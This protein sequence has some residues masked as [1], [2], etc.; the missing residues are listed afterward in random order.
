MDIVAGGY[1][2]WV[3]RK[4]PSTPAKAGAQATRSVEGSNTLRGAPSPGNRKLSYKDQ[5]DLDRLPAEV[6]RLEREI[7]ATETALHDPDLYA[8]SPAKFDQLTRT[9][10]S[11][12]TEKDAAEMRWLEV[13]EMAEQLAAAQ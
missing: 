11:L 13:A 3:K 2:D 4:L 12:R 9:A 6:E 5:R 1:E 10:Q 7:S 8:K